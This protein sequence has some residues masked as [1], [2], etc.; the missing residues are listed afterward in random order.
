MINKKLCDID[1]EIIQ[2]LK[3]NEIPESRTLEY[4]KEISLE[5]RE[6]KKEF[7]ADV[8]SF[9]NTLGGDLI[10]GI[11]EKNGIPIK[12]DGIPID[13]IDSYKNRLDSIIRDSIIPNIPHYDIQEIQLQNGH[14]VIIIRIGESYIAPHQVILDGLL[15]SRENGGKF[16]K[17]HTGGK[18]PMDVFELKEAFIKSE[19]LSNK[20]RAFIKDRVKNIKNAISGITDSSDDIHYTLIPKQLEKLPY[21]VLHIIPLSYF[22]DFNK[23]IIDL[24]RCYDSDGLF[25]PIYFSNST[26]NFIQFERKFNFEGLVKFHHYIKGYIQIFRN[27]SIETIENQNYFYSED[28]FF[29]ISHFEHSIIESLKY[30][31]EEYREFDIN[32]PFIIYLSLL[33]IKQYKIKQFNH[34]FS[35]YQGNHFSDRDNV[36]LPE[37]IISDYNISIE[38][39]LKNVFDVLWNAFS[40]PH[41]FNYDED[42]NW[43]ERWK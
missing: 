27:G 24:K 39:E 35:L 3:T 21:I 31:L 38:K 16:F 9:A 43:K 22:T 41:S 11:E 29:K 34:H 40:L 36:I 15:Y 32:P 25:M 26:D 20:V 10:I 8:S 2:S 13:N 14:Y 1:Q 6:Q 17:R 37:I 42:G 28:M 7:L 19:S 23:S 18:H 33:G 30:Y 5:K 12:I 4:K